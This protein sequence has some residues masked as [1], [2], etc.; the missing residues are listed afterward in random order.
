MEKTTS[1]S[2]RGRLTAASNGTVWQVTIPLRRA[3]LARMFRGAMGG[4]FGDD[5]TRKHREPVLNDV[6]A[7]HF[8]D[9]PK[10]I[11]SKRHF[12]GGPSR[13]LRCTEVDSSQDWSELRRGDLILVAVGG[14]EYELKKLSS[15]PRLIEH[16]VGPNRDQLLTSYWNARVRSLS[17]TELNQWLRASGSCAG[18]PAVTE[19]EQPRTASA[20]TGSLQ[21]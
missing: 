10:G 8:K 12:F 4:V 13:P 19:E 17:S 5:W 16:W 2:Q 9:L 1:G 15:R 20:A 3:T 14:G 6:D 7:Q 18:Q 11:E 21:Q